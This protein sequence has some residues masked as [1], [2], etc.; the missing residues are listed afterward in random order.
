MNSY[1]D[2]A[3]LRLRK[4]DTNPK[5]NNRICH[6]SEIED[7]TH[8]LLCKR[9]VVD[10]YANNEVELE[11]DMDSALNESSY[12]DKLVI[13]GYISCFKRNRKRNNIRRKNTL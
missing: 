11:K 3:M 10:S 1:Y 4:S 9:C 7:A 6:I 12:A 5:G 8:K 13:E 2:D